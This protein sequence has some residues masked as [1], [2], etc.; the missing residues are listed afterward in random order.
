MATLNNNMRSWLSRIISI[1]DCTELRLRPLPLS[2]HHHD[3]HHRRRRHHH[4]HRRHHRHHR[5]YSWSIHRTSSGQF[6]LPFE[7]QEESSTCFDNW[8]VKNR[9]CQPPIRTGVNPVF[10]RNLANNNNNNSSSNN[11]NNNNSKYWKISECLLIIVH[12]PT[13]Q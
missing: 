6:H 12:V 7:P 13:S 5:H 10:Q 4:H 1:Q 9:N 11:N 3:N 2:Y 8:E